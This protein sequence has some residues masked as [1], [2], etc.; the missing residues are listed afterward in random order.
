MAFHKDTVMADIATDSLVLHMAAQSSLSEKHG[1]HG[2]ISNN[3]LS[4][5]HMLEVK[6]EQKRDFSLLTISDIVA[7][8][9][10]CLPS[11]DLEKEEL[12]RQMELGHKKRQDSVDSTYAAQRVS[13]IM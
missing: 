1:Y 5:C 7:L 10:P 3:T 13:G 8:L 6:L 12:F 4:H 9:A 2:V 11:C